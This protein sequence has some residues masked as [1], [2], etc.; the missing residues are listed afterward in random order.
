MRVSARADYALR[1]FGPT[2]LETLTL[3]DI[4]SREL[5]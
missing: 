3:A 5:W 2:F 4:V 1:A